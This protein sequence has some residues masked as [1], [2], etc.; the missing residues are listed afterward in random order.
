MVGEGVQLVE[1]QALVFTPHRRYVDVPLVGF[2]H[3]R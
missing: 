2:A 3:E 1:R